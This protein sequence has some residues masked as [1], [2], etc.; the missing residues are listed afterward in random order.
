M[1]ERTF[2]MSVPY[3][4]HKGS[5]LDQ[6]NKAFPSRGLFPR[7]PGKRAIG[8]NDI[9]IDDHTQD[10]VFPLTLGLTN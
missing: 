1:D 9:P 3:A 5:K 6:P 2:G 10:Y 8:D 7:G 4:A